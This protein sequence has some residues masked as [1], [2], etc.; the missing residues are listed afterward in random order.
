VVNVIR[1]GYKFVG[2]LA[3]IL[4]VNKAVAP[5]G[6]AYFDIDIREPGMTL[7]AIASILGH[8]FSPFLHFWGVIE[9]AVALVVWIGLTIW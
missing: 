7:V 8:L 3:L 1:G 4:N 2:L 9:Y 5:V 6:I